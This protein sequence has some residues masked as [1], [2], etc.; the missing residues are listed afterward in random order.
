MSSV[1]VVTASFSA[2]SA[3]VR[4]PLTAAFSRR[5]LRFSCLLCFGRCARRGARS[6]GAGFVRRDAAVVRGPGAM[7]GV[8][9]GAR[10]SFSGPLSYYSPARA[11]P[12]RAH[13]ATL[14]ACP[15]LRCPWPALPA[16]TISLPVRRALVADDIGRVPVRRFP[17]P[18]LLPSSSPLVLIAAGLS[19]AGISDV[20][21]PTAWLVARGWAV[22]CSA[23]S[24]C[25]FRSRPGGNHMEC[26]HDH[27]CVLPGTS[28]PRS[29]SSPSATLTVLLFGFTSHQ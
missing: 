22:V 16:K 17:S 15:S 26:S 29:T 6:R 13:S 9:G 25:T 14:G 4:Y 12:S 2:C 28:A 1:P 7:R 27:P 21:S 24:S 3:A 11:Q 19:G 20:P 10:R 5:S 23:A 18:F 8:F